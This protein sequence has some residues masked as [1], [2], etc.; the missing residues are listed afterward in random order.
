ML[1]FS[2]PGTFGPSLPC[3]LESQTAKNNFTCFH[4]IIFVTLKINVTRLLCK[5]TYIDA[6]NKLTLKYRKQTK[7][8]ISSIHAYICSLLN[9][10]GLEIQGQALMLQGHI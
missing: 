3:A 2:T 5:V 10:R 7:V 9:M 1:I 4:M 6:L 8:N